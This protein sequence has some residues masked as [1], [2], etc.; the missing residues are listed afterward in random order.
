MN[1]L[2]AHQCL[3]TDA[4]PADS[5]LKGS[6]E[7]RQEK[8][9]GRLALSRDTF[10]LGDPRRRPVPRL[11]AQDRFFPRMYFLLDFSFSF[12]TF[13][14]LP[15][16]LSR[17]QILRLLN[18]TLSFNFSDVLTHL[19]SG[20]TANAGWGAVEEHVHLLPCLLTKKLSGGLSYSSFNNCFS[21][22]YDTHNIKFIILKCK[23]SSF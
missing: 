4:N 20:D 3:E 2:V 9:E 15:S 13:W 8:N 21:I 17:K 14:V 23:L 12:A 5:P 6:G 7:T 22:S 19:R 1:F 16:T 11:G 10:H 18:K